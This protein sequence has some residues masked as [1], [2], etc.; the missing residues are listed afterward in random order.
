VCVFFFHS[1]MLYPHSFWSFTPSLPPLHTLS[2][3]T[4]RQWSIDQK[5]VMYL[6]IASRTHRLSTWVTVNFFSLF[7]CFWLLLSSDKYSWILYVLG[8]YIIYSLWGEKRI[9]TRDKSMEES[10]QN[11]MK[12]HTGWSHTEWLAS[13]YFR[14]LDHNSASYLRYLLYATCISDCPR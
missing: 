2:S 3:L 5:Y 8:V 13:C 14:L 12:S 6:N 7:F 4:D 9:K 11:K 1:K 10:E